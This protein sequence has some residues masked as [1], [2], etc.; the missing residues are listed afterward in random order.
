MLVKAKTHISGTIYNEDYNFSFPVAAPPPTLIEN[1]EYQFHPGHM[2]IFPPDSNITTKVAIPTKEYISL[3]INKEYLQRV[4]YEATGKRQ[5]SFRYNE[6]AYTQQLARLI[7]QLDEEIAT[8]GGICNL[9]LQSISAQIAITILRETGVNQDQKDIKVRLQEHYIRDAL[10]YIHTNYSYNLVLEDICQHINLS[11][12][13][14]VRLFKKAT[15]FSPHVYLMK[16]RLMKAQELLA[17]GHYPIEEIC[18]K[19][20]FINTSHFA[21]RFK[22]SFGMSPT[23]YRKT[24]RK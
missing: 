4:L 17:K 13:Y 7:G 8:Y 23:E 20:G 6:Y 3:S 16:T 10:D 12:Y 2:I 1:K 14:F 18:L 24:I 9:M 5:L 22:R 19:C 11:P 15:G 21:A